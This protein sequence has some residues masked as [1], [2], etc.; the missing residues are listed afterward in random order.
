LF[1]Q[2]DTSWSRARLDIAAL[3]KHDLY[4]EGVDGEAVLWAS[5]RLLEQPDRRRTLIVIS[6]GC[7][8]DS[9]TQHVNDDFYLASHLQQ[10]IRQTIS[11]GIDVVGL[12][13]GLD[14]SAYY[15]RS[16]AVDLQQALTP[17]VF[18]DIAR[19]LAGGHRR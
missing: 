5:Q 16:L 14:L 15:P 3:L 17:A 4:R 8:M 2:A 13:V 12:G 18:Y 11:Q 6:D 7:P 19:L 9:A 1:K 10:V